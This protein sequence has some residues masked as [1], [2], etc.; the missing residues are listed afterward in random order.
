MSNRIEISLGA[1]APPLSEQLPL[2][3]Q[4]AEHFDRIRN[5]C[6]ILRIHHYLTPKEAEKVE[7]RLIGSIIAEL[8][9]HHD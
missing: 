5:A 1:L 4:A 6:N 9:K 7:K 8:E 3:K 2:S